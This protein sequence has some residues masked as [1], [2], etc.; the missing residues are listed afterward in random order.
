MT[1]CESPHS[2]GSQRSGADEAAARFRPKARLST[3]S[4]FFQGI[5]KISTQRFYDTSN[6]W[7]FVHDSEFRLS[8]A[9]NKPRSEAINSKYFKFSSHRALTH[10]A[11]VTN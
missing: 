11:K 7:K 9:T 1:N 4:Y 2:R 8:E 3:P 5:L 6:T 10:A